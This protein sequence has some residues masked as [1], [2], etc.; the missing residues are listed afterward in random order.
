MTTPRRLVLLFLGLLVA[1]SL[2]AAQSGWVFYNSAHTLTY[3]NDALGNRLPDFS[4]AGYESGGV[5]IPANQIVRTNL[6]A[7]AGDNTA[8]IQAALN[9][10]SALAP[11]A[12]G[13]RGV[14]LLAP[15]TFTIG[16]SLTITNGGV[17]LRGSGNNTNAGT[18]LLVTNFARNVL[19][20]QGSGTWT[21]TGVSYTITDP[22]VSLGATNFHINGGITWGTNV[23]VAAD[24][25]VF[26]NGTLLYAYDWANSN[27][28]VHGVTFTGAATASTTNVTLTGIGS[29]YTG[30]N[31]S[32]APFSTL[33]AAYRSILT[34]GQ[35][36]SSP[37][38]ATVTLSNLTAGHSYAVQVWISDPR[39]GGVA[40]RTA[41]LLGYNQVTLAY[42]VP[43]A[44][45]GVGQYSIG[46][47]IATAASQSFSL[48]VTNSSGS[49]QLNALLVSDITA[50]G[51]QPLNPAAATVLTAG[52]SVV[53]QRP[54]TQSWIDAIGMNLLT[55]PWG[56]GTGLEFERQLT[57]V[58]GNQLTIDIP[59]CN[60]IESAWTTGQVFAVTDTARIQ[61]VGLENFCAIGQIADYPS[62]ILAGVFAN[63]L[64]A[65]NCWARNLLLSGWGNGLTFGGGT[66]WCTGQDCQYVSPATGTSSAA[67][68]A[69]TIVDCQCLFQRC[70]SDGGYYHIMVTQDSTPGPNVFLNLT[71]TGTHYNGGPHQRW[72]A[73]VLHDV[74]TM[75]ADTLGGYTPYLAVNN[76][77]NDGSGQGWAAGFSVMYNCQVPQFQ[78]E[79]PNTTTNQYNWTIGGIGSADNYSDK[80]IYDALGTILNPRSLYLEQ[81]RERL[82]GAAIENIGYSLFTLGAPASLSVYPGT[83]AT[84]AVTLGDPALMSNLVALAV[85]GLPA[86]VSAAWSTNV[87]TG[88]GTATLTLT[89]ASSAAPG[90]Y[91]LTVTGTNAGLTH[92]TN[93][94]LAVTALPRPVFTGVTLTGTNLIGRG[95]NG[96]PGWPCRVL[97]TTNLALPFSSW[98][99]IATNT[100]DSTGHFNFTNAGAAA[101]RFYILQTP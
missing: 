89:A 66:K 22:Y 42:N 86:G 28:T 57:A 41:M 25:D 55:N 69:W 58:H 17:I 60:P 13:S 80:G 33:S 64:N 46:T 77:G 74:V 52:Q 62:N 87:V 81:L 92:G 71:C 94:T 93:V 29:Y 98:T 49:T 11:D 19:T 72:A 40:G 30:Y 6:T 75:G 43:A 47:F 82:G 20:V 8:A 100:F 14:V 37:D 5:A 31:S 27:A 39:G 99:A 70:T 24:T 96:L 23:T 65:K 83:N 54:Q 84:L 38:T 1:N 68:A 44:T 88:A 51:Y 59:L 26:T 95:T 63:F 48:S 79:Q 67:P 34:G 21:Q 90:S 7:L 12:N 76:R 61:Q 2:A 3:S 85:S 32:S 50:T 45:G 35:Y 9:Y 91:P 73:G 15:G 18:I 78:L 56:P 97:A 36:S 4:Y 16:G 10:V 53:I 101:V